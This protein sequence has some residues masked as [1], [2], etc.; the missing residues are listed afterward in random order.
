MVLASA[1]LLHSKPADARNGNIYLQLAPSWGVYNTDEVIIDDTEDG[2]SEPKFPQ[3]GFTPQLKIGFNLFGWA[4]AELDTAVF[5]WDL[6]NVKRGGGGFLG[7]AVRITP[8][9][10]LT[11]IL[12]E[13][14]EIPSLVPEGP[15][16]WKDR[17]F[18]LGVTFGGGYHM[19][20]E[21]YAYQGPYFKWALDAQFYITP[22]FALGIELPFRHVFLEPF[23]YTNYEDSLGLCTDGADAYG[24]AGD[25]KTDPIPPQP[26]RNPYKPF[27]VNASQLDSLCD[28]PAPA[29]MFFAPTFT[30]TGAF[31]FGI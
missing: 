14:V 22:Q 20:G 6:F 3:A 24:Y 5:G 1:A 26:S 2:A 18:D 30:I 16:S 13:D 7:G 11:H 27:E 17:P 21:D 4:G 19:V 8:L 31:D 9:E 12:A 23:R 28:D 29:A 25:N 15:V 10:I